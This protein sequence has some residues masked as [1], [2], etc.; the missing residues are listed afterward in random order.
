M[1]TQRPVIQSVPTTHAIPDAMID[2]LRSGFIHGRHLASR[3]HRY[4]LLKTIAALNTPIWGVLDDGAGHSRNPKHIRPA[5]GVLLYPFDVG[6]PRFPD[7]YP[8]AK[9]GDYLAMLRDA[10]R[11]PDRSF[12]AMRIPADGVKRDD[13]TKL[14]F[15]SYHGMVRFFEEQARIFPERQTPIP[16]TSEGRRT[17]MAAW[18]TRK[19][20]PF[21]S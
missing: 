21:V 6:R 18:A 14:A 5:F 7:N 11:L 12:Y 20:G 16:F 3:S 15:L 17:I 19:I 4:G 1:G 9:P 10:T 8:L 2:E 13:Q